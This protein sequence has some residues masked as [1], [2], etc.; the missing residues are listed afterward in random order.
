LK[1]PAGLDFG[2]LRTAF[3]VYSKVVRDKM[4][5]TEASARLD[6]LMV[7]PPKYA[8]WKSVIIGGIASAAIIPSGE[9]S[10]R[11]ISSEAAKLIL[12]V[13]PTAFYGSFIDVLAVIPLGGL[14]VVVQVLLARN[15][16]YS[17]LFE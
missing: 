8:L 3:W 6:E 2:K 17:S 15:D 11:R 12:L 10:S 7:A 1:Q 4:K 14:L 16:L 13:L 9:S 5:V